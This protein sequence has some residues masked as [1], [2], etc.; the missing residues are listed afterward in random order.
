[1][2]DVDAM[3]AADSQ[4]AGFC[5]IGFQWSFSSAIQA[6]KHDIL[7]GR[8]G[9]MRQMKTIIGWPRSHAYYG[10]NDWA[11]QIRSATGQLVL[12][13]PIANATAHFLHNCFMCLVMMYAA[14]PR[15]QP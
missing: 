6:L 5:A 14:V 7:A 10:R 3:I 4:A 8:W 12:D 9:A 2:Q 11:G 13:S 15:P 1:M